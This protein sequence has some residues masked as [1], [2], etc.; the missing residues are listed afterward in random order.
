MSNCNVNK[1]LLVLY[2]IDEQGIKL[3]SSYTDNNLVG[4]ILLLLKDDKTETP[5]VSVMPENNTSSSNPSSDMTT[6]STP[7]TPSELTTPSTP[8]TPTTTSSNSGMT[9]EYF[10]NINKKT[11]NYFLYIVIFFLFVII[12]INLFNK[13]CAM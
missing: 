12:V 1:P 3:P 6:P 2:G 4:D 10:T 5:L 9:A 11:S 7:T 8:T 13:K